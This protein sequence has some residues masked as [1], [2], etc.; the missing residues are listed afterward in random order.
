MHTF[1][2]A[3]GRRSNWNLQKMCL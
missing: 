2:S 3:L 1:M